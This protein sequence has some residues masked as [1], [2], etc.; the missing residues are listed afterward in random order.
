MNCND[1]VYYRRETDT[2]FEYCIKTPFD[3]ERMLLEN[4]PHY[5]NHQDAK[6]DTKYGD[7]DHY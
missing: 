4:C 6:D 5:Y 1:C 3:S 7:K 2:N